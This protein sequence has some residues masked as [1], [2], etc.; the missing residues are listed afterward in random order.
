MVWIRAS[1]FDSGVRRPTR[2]G[3]YLESDRVEIALQS[4]ALGL[5]GLRSI[6]Q[7]GVDVPNSRVRRVAGWQLIDPVGLPAPGGP[8]DDH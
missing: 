1:S 7:Q 2:S 6:T 3:L 8:Q 5:V 4:S